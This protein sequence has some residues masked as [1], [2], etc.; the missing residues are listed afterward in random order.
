MYIVTARWITILHPGF[1]YP[2]QY[3]ILCGDPDQVD[4]QNMEPLMMTVSIITEYHTKYV[5]M[6][7]TGSVGKAEVDIS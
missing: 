7:K 5:H 4:M 1:D 6:H 3:R 2:L